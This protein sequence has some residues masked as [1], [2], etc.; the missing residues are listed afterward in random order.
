MVGA[1]VRPDLLGPPPLKVSIAEASA[2]RCART[3]LLSPRGDAG[4]QV[5]T[6]LVEGRG[7]GRGEGRSEGEGEGRGEGEGQSQGWAW[8]LGEGS[9]LAQLIVHLRLECPWLAPHA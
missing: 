8:G 2:L 5:V 7:E 3:R 4:A 6:H 1:R 9:G